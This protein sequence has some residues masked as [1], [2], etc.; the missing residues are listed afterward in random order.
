MNFWAILA[1]VAGGILLVILVAIG[2]GVKLFINY[3]NQ[4]DEED[5]EILRTS[6]SDL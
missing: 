3:M 1:W 2:Y 6:G 4:L 5:E